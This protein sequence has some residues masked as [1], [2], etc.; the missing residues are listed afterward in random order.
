MFDITDSQY[1]YDKFTLKLVTLFVFMIN[2]SMNFDHGSVPAASKDIKE[3]MNINNEML[4]GLGS[5]V[6]L[7]IITGSLFGTVI[8]N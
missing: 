6:F 5:L 4:G 7:G 8:F 1:K 3:E 2:L